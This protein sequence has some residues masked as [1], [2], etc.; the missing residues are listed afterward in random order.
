M[1]NIILSLIKLI[2]I[3]IVSSLFSTYSFASKSANKLI[4][5]TPNQAIVQY[6]NLNSLQKKQWIEQHLALGKTADKK[7]Y[8]L[9]A[10]YF[11][12][13]K[14]YKKANEHI[15]L[16][17]SQLTKS[18]PTLLLA[19]AFYLKAITVS[20]GLRQFEGA[21]PLFQQTINIL[22]D[23]DKSES[24]TLLSVFANY[25][26][27]S[28]YLFVEQS[29]S[30][31][32]FINSS[33][34]L[35]KTLKDREV[36]VVPMLELAKYYMAMN[37]QGLAESQLI[38]TYNIAVETG[39]DQ[40]PNL[41]QQLS[42]YYRKNERFNL[43]IDYA[44]KAVKYYKKT[45][46]K[47]LLAGAYNNLAVT[48]EASGDLNMALV[49][50][51]NTIKLVE[52]NPQN[53]FLA[54]ATHN[55][56][57]IFKQQ[58]K[59]DN[60]LEYLKKANQYFTNIG[61]HY[62]LMS[63]ELGIANTLIDLKQ[64]DEAIGF[65][66][67]ALKSAILLSKTDMQIEA[68]EYLSNAYQKMQ[69]F[70]KSVQ[71]FTKLTI[72]KNKQIDKLSL[73]STKNKSGSNELDLRTKISDAKNTITKKDLLIVKKNQSLWRLEVFLW[74]ALLSLSVMIYLIIKSKN[75]NDNLSSLVNKNSITQLNTLHD[76]KFLLKIASDQFIKNKYVMTIQLPILKA[77]FNM[78]GIE[79]SNKLSLSIIKDLQLFLKESL[80]QVAEDTF[81]FSTNFNE[82]TDIE[83]FSSSLISYYETL[84]PN[85]L[86]PLHYNNLLLL[87]G[88]SPHPAQSSINL[89][90]A[91]N[92]IGLS[93]TALSVVVANK[94]D[95][96]ANNWLIFNEKGEQPTTLF[97]IS[98]R[99]EWLKMAHNQ[100]LTVNTGLT[101]S[102]SWLS[103]PHFDA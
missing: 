15:D 9:A 92:I 29:S 36:V 95:I 73:K 96:P 46:Q 30:A 94:S 14:K 28:L 89:I 1:K 79:Q 12:L 99:Q 52:S 3:I 103:T 20:I 83:T 16:L 27:G 39:S 35:A 74:L 71:A 19:N 42:R 75:K 37:E 81:V 38:A 50:Y 59:L 70:E 58:N 13:T 72:L 53:Y 57:L 43:A 11:Y 66:E 61:H 82:E 85:S 49:H 26:L 41:L 54:L 69:Q 77:L 63:N 86:L 5:V 24:S 78:M 64:F 51:L 18:S 55:I 98:T 80:Y 76:D 25:R 22:K 6:D 100:M 65:A 7:D 93:L 8:L 23:V 32:K 45:P 87:G 10:K 48:Y 34:K 68:L 17:L 67:K 60:A 33:I 40:R 4:Y 97:A 90:Q 88:M 91:K 62:F 21:I 84:I 101:N 2:T 47:N 56:G 31:N 44:N 102:I